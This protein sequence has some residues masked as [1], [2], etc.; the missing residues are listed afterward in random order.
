[1]KPLELLKK[2]C[3][4]NNPYEVYVLFGIS[5][6]KDNDCTGGQEKVFRE[7]IKNAGE[8]EKKY[9]RLKNS[10]LAYRDSDGREQK[11]YLYISVNARNTKKAFFLMQKE[12][13]VT[14]EELSNQVDVTN[15]LNRVDRYWLS[16]LM[17]P[18]S[19][20]G[21]GKFL[22]DIDFKGK[23][24]LDSLLDMIK[25]AT[26]IK[27]IQETKNGYH[28]LTEPFNRTEMTNQS[29]LWDYQIKTDSLLFVEWVEVK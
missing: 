9:H 11:F 22:F 20:A 14:N 18:T 29:V 23:E 25:K 8:I 26:T 12:M 13:L 1:M 5:R 4:F 2:H 24:K 3:I 17:R 10:V 6:K 19:R 21:R 16:C 7:V 28:V 27:L 15:K